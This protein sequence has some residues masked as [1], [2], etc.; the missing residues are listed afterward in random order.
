MTM[1]TLSY[2]ILHYTAE[3]IWSRCLF[4]FGVLYD[5]PRCQSVSIQFFLLCFYNMLWYFRIICIQ[6]HEMFTSLKQLVPSGLI[7]RLSAI[8]LNLNSMEHSVCNLSMPFY[9]CVVYAILPDCM[10]VGSGEVEYDDGQSFIKRMVRG[11]VENP[12]LYW[13]RLLCLYTQNVY[14]ARILMIGWFSFNLS[15]KIL[16]SLNDFFLDIRFG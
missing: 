15:Y 12:L 1:L 3:W 7:P 13:D 2:N 11:M 5:T 14:C 16:C 9:E 4:L 8:D 10:Q 6:V